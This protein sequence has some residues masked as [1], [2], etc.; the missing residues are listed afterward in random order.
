MVA[1]RGESRE[2]EGERE[3]GQWETSCRHTVPAHVSGGLLGKERG[4]I[5]DEAS[6]LPGLPGLPA[7]QARPAFPC[8]WPAL[9]LR[10]S[11]P[12]PL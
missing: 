1:A 10:S 4:Q 5:S 8:T 6:G 2:S 7:L 9:L 12:S 11:S 3:S